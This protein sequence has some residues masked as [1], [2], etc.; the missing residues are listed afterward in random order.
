MTEP[1]VPVPARWTA[2]ISLATLGLFTAFYG[3]LQVLLAEQAKALAPGHKELA[4]GI[5]TGFGA[6]FS[7]IGNPLF[8]AISDRTTWRAGR[9][10]PWVVLGVLGGV[11]SLA[12]LA[13]RRLFS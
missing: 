1:T 3:P 8:G 12:L 7:V 9:R 11:A 6:A 5:V 2:F 4:L 13:G 10:L